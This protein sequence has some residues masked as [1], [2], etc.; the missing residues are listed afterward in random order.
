MKWT[1]RCAEVKMTEATGLNVARAPFIIEHIQLGGS[2][3]AV[4]V[5]CNKECLMFEPKL[6][7][8]DSS[9]PIVVQKEP[10]RV[11]SLG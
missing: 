9:I 7:L 10:Y 3:H 8:E 5:V 11:R 1:W 6:P 2:M 4:C